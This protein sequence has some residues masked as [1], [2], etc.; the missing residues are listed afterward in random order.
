[1]GRAISDQTH[2]SQHQGCVY[3]SA[4]GDVVS[5]QIDLPQNQGCLLCSN[6][7]GCLRSDRSYN[8]RSECC[9]ATVDV[10]SD[11]TD[12]PQHRWCVRCSAMGRA[13]S[14]QTDLPQHQWAV[15]SEGRADHQLNHTAG[16]NQTH[17]PSRPPPETHDPRQCFSTDRGQGRPA[18]G[19]S[20]VWWTCA[21]GPAGT[22]SW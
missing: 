14:D 8:S 13:V 19:R 11:Q 18:P 4:M 9:Y 15:L 10:V 5:D 21:N 16:L 17:G 7:Q 2:L 20:S 1:M 12:L 6:G 3:C 22:G